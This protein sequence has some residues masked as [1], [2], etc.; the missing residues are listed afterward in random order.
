MHHGERNLQ[1]RESPR[2]ASSVLMAWGVGRG[3]GWTSQKPQNAKNTDTGVP[4]APH[5]NKKC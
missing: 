2:R 3:G 5:R 4:H 1:T